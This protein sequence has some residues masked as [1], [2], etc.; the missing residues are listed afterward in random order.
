MPEQKKV[1][2]N[3]ENITKRNPRLDTILMVENF[4]KEN[5]GSYKKT[6]LFNNLPKKT[7]WGTFNVIL[8]YLWQDNKIGIDRKGHVVYVWNPRVAK[9]FINKKKY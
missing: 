8:K 9:K 5:S 3:T 2:F 6:E 1:D 4:I 7:M